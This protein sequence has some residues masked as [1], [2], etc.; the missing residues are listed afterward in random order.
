LDIYLLRPDNTLN[1][2]N[3]VPGISDHSGVLL[4]VE[5]DENC[6]ETKIERIVPVYHKTD[7]LGLQNFLRENFNLWAENGSSIEEIWRSYKEI[8]FNRAWVKDSLRYY[9]GDQLISEAISFKYLGIIIRSD[10]SWADHVNYT[11]R[12]A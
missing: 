4:E 9:I 12:K 5:W 11:L 8:V 10:L 6:R 3:I 2:C 1:S 7:V